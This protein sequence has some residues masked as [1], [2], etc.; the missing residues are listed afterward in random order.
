MAK[1]A[2]L[3]S[4]YNQSNMKYIRDFVH[5]KVSVWKKGQEL[6]RVAGYWVQTF[7]HK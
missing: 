4:L 5:I 1:W 3:P 7:L 2:E 6:E